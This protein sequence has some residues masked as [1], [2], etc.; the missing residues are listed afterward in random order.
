MADTEYQYPDSVD[1]AIIGG[2]PAGAAAATRLAQAGRSVLVLERRRHPR[3]HIGESMLPHTMAVLERLGALDLVQQ[4]GYVTKR[5]A[6]FIFADGEYRR[7]AFADQ[8]PGRHPETFQCERAHLDRLLVQHARDTGATVLEEAPVHDLVIEQ[9]RV[10]GLK[11]QAGGETRTVRAKYVIDAGGRASKIT[12][13]FNLRRPAEQIRNVAV[14]RHYTGLDEKY[15]PGYDGDIQVGGHPDGWVWAIPIWS[16]VISIGTVMPKDV[17]RDGNPE[18]LFAEHL[19]RVPRITARI[20]GTEPR[21][22][23]RIE[24][25]Y[26]YYSDTITGP[27]W[28]LVG[29]SACFGDPI[30]SGGVCMALTTGMAA[31][32]RV[33]E[34]LSEPHREEEVQHLY[35]RF[36]K[37]GYDTYARLIYAYYESQYNLGKYLR[38][39]GG[40]VQGK[41]FT[42]ILSGDF[43]SEHNPISQLLRSNPNWDTF[44][45]FEPL[46]GCPLY[47][48]LNAEEQREEA[49]VAAA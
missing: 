45:P 37:T 38:S 28:F 16:D 20:T 46:Y 30:F 26:N 17:L 33:D 5:G 43:W 27:G 12:Q 32:E 10:V 14:Y 36:Y 41:W 8:G 4:Q 15:N 7:I 31:A 1:V 18:K 44:S 13:T 35:S 42:R 47:G 11:Y 9:G 29:D 40:D 19:S 2:G 21:G 23:L 6:E 25:D 22:E 3:F 24:A 39:L 49:R 48:D 34:L